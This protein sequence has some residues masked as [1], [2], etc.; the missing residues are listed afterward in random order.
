MSLEAVSETPDLHHRPIQRHESNA[1]ERC[2]GERE[3][4]ND[5]KRPGLYAYTIVTSVRPLGRSVDQR[6]L[7]FVRSFVFSI[8]P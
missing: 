1:L 3:N 2:W 6:T 8:A 5:K 7:N 4:R